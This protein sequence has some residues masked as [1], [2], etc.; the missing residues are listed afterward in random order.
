[1]LAKG[2]DVALFVLARAGCANQCG[3]AGISIGV[4]LQALGQRDSGTDRLENAAMVAKHVPL[5]VLRVTATKTSALRAV[6]CWLG[7]FGLIPDRFSAP[8]TG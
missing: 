7:A 2:V 5:E 1:M 3:T 4:A 8:Y 6:R